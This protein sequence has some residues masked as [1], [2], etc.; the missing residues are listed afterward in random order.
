MKTPRYLKENDTVALAA[1]ARSISPAEINCA[2]RWLQK[3]GFN[4]FYDERLFATENQFAG[5]DSLRATYF[6]YLLDNADIQAIWCVRGGYGSARIIDRLDFSKF[7]ENPKWICGY[8]DITVFHNHVQQNLGIA[9]IHCTM[10]IN[11]TGDEASSQTCNSLLD[12]LTGKELSYNIL[13]H[14]LSRLGDF[15]GTITGGNISVIH[16]LIGSPSDIMTD[17]KVLLLEDLDEYLY[18][19]DRM[20]L[21]IKRNGKLKNLKAL[22][23][24]HLNNMHDNTIPFGKTAE[25]IILEHCSEYGYPVIFNIPAGHLADNRAFRLGC[26]TEGSVHDNVF[27]ISNRTI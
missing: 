16:S 11:V 27:K 17:N 25:E 2:E 21:N 1:P 5:S 24:G 22:L 15:T 13:P 3:C 12:A 20:M 14:K 6:Q 8:S 18:H 19:I 26:L 9:T 10:P 4:V 7:A 23:V